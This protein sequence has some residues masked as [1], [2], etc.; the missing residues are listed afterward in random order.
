MT[1]TYRPVTG[2]F[3]GDLRTDVLWYGAGAAPDSLWLAEPARRWTNKVTS[4]AG[5]YEPVVGDFDQDDR[6]DVLWYGSGSARDGLWLGGIGGLP[7]PFGLGP[8]RRH[9]P[10]R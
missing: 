4:V 1:G 8:V 6:S 5:T 10:R 2:D 9:A 3:D 7:V